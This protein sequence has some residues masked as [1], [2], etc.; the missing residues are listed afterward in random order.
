MPSTLPSSAAQA[1]NPVV[2]EILQGRQAPPSGPAQVATAGT[3][4]TSR[5]RCPMRAS[6]STARRRG[7]GVHQDQLSVV[8]ELA[9]SAAREF[10]VQVYWS[11]DGHDRMQLLHNAS[12]AS[13]DE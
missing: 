4:S 9:G 1:V 12:R 8:I 11:R 7:T 10:V 3:L 13:L 6:V 2:V 5:L